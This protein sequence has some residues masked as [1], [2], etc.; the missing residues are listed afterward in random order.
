MSFIEIM[1][2]HDRQVSA[3]RRHATAEGHT[4]DTMTVLE[5]YDRQLHPWIHGRRPVEIAA[6]VRGWLAQ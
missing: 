2:Q 3:T 5:S 6:R 4:V 1:R